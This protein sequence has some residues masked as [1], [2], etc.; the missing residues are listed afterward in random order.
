MIWIKRYGRVVSIK[1]LNVFR[2]LESG[3]GDL[4][5]YR[6]LRLAYAD[7]CSLI[8]DPE[9]FDGMPVGLQ[10]M[11]RRLEEEKVL[12]IAREMEQLLH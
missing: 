2:S 7:N 1:P 9:T 6:L 10:I 8:D 4:A 3:C 12:A 11:G 5:Y